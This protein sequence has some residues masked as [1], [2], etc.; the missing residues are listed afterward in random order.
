[1]EVTFSSQS[2]SGSTCSWIINGNN[3][4]NLDL[5][6][7]LFEFE[8]NYLIS[9]VCTSSTGCISSFDNYI[10]VLEPEVS[11]YIPNAFSPNGD[12]KNEIFQPKGTGL[13]ELNGA[14]FNR[15]GEQIYSWSGLENGWDG[16]VN[17]LKV[18][19]GIY[20]Y[21]INGKYNNSRTFT[22]V[23]SVMLIE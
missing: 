22:K 21:I 6:P 18:Q 23:G 5:A 10:N 15:W 7:Y 9:Q 4:P 16:T 8:G 14:I 1:L 2:S 17:G 20:A 11:L 19:N 13:L 12:S 3:A